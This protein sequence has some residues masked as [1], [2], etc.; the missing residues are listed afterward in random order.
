MPASAAWM[1]RP[2]AVDPVNATL[3][4]PGAR[5]SAAPVAPSP[6]RIETTPGGSSASWQISAS[7]SAVSGVVS[8]GLR[9]AALPQASAGASFHAA[10]SSGKFHGTIWPTTPSGATSRAPTP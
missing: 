5:T 8:A 7:S 4:M 9:I 1:S 10:I 2:T 3:S 6:G